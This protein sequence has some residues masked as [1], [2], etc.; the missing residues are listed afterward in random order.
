[1]KS[2]RAQLYRMFFDFKELSL[3]D[4]LY[5]SSS[6]EIVEIDI[7]HDT[8]K[9][10]Y[11]T[12]GKYFIPRLE[13][14][15]LTL[16]DFALQGIVHPDDIEIFNN[17]MN[18][19]DI[20]ERLRN[21][22]DTPNFLMDHF[23]YR[24]QNGNW[25]WVE[26]CVITGK[27]NN[28][29]EGKIV[30]FMKDIE[31]QYVRE[32]GEV[33]LKENLEA[34]IGRDELTRLNRSE[35]FFEHA[36]DKIEKEPKQ[37]W[38]LIAIDI[39]NFRLFDEWYG[40]KDGDLLLAK[41]GNYLLLVEEKYDCLGG[42]FGQDDFALLIAY[43][44]AAIKEIYAGL[45]R[46]TSQYSK[47]AG[48]A[49]AFGVYLIKDDI[50]IKDAYALAGIAS[51][52]SKKDMNHRITV[53]DE[54][55]KKKQ[56]TEYHILSEA[57]EGLRND[58]ITFFL[59]PQCRISTKKI[60]GAESLARWIKKDGTIIPP[61]DFIPVLE[62]TGFISDLDKI[63]WE[64]VFVWLRDYI[65]TGKKPVPISLNVSRED[66][67]AIDV[68]EYLIG[69]ADKYK[70]PHN[71]I[72][73]EIT[74]SSYA[75]TTEKI[76]QLVQKLRESGFTVL[77]DDFGS[78]YS[79]LNVLRE[80]R[81][82]AIKLD[83]LFLN[84]KKDIEKGINILESVINMTKQLSLPII[85]EGVEELKQVEFLR[86]L[87]CRYIQGYYFYKPM[88]VSDFEKL[89]SNEEIIDDGG[90]QFK[91]N[92]QFRVQEFLDKNIY[93]DAMLNSILGPTAIYA[94]KEE[95]V[96]IIR[97]NE[98]FYKA[99]NVPDFMDKIEHIQNV[100]PETDRQN[101][102]KLLGEAVDNRLNGSSGRLRFARSDGTLASF[103]IHF[104]YLGEREGTK[105]FYGSATNVTIFADLKEHLNLIAEYS[106]DSLVFVKFINGKWTYEVLSNTL[107][108]LVGL[109]REQ[110]EAE[111]NN[112]KFGERVVN[113]EEIKQLLASVRSNF[114]KYGDFKRDVLIRSKNG[115]IVKVKFTC[116]SVAC[117]TNNIKFILFTDIIK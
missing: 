88:P 115:E 54:T 86:S 83:A 55:F 89:I 63:L 27:E 13:S 106:R 29:E 110:L 67:V 14:S 26:Q 40:R 45:S 16:F 90:F 17:L 39:E 100:M 65:S 107:S 94:W 32:Q 10:I 70:V 3:I 62:K 82:D 8:F 87:G 47:S 61:S 98:Q 102:Y 57:M 53:Y 92:Q 112:G 71:L 34:A 52:K 93:S 73:I 74:E 28:I 105:R 33:S 24:L 97:Y 51:S 91:H 114:E 9:Q 44:E 116:K 12:E 18:P 49:P 99:V 37:K 69:L 79:S 81:V 21:N 108:D 19:R 78:G 84:F 36:K 95:N 48:F 11:H 75:E 77:M 46:L 104:F 60:V 109:N 15:F 35:H 96:D 59:Q 64:K 66:V 111:L 30:V 25:R 72:K 6:D 43:D 22:K 80:I 58:E 76:S 20:L 2:K 56:E 117:K 85:V 101:L 38:S 7:L 113:H 41:I 4:Y 42:Y 68:P 103:I 31:N 5:N 50:N 1:M 23:R